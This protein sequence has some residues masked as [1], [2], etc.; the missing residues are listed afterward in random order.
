MLVSRV[1]GQRQQDCFTIHPDR[2]WHQLTESLDQ[3]TTVLLVKDLEFISTAK[4]YFFDFR[5]GIAL[6]LGQ[7]G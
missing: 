2:L 4:I 7:S 1:L 5:V 6:D 3:Q